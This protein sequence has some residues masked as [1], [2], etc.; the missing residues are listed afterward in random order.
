MLQKEL[1]NT[2]SEKKVILFISGYVFLLLFFCS[3]MSPLFYSNEWA[4]VNIY[5]NVAK[6]MLNGRTLYTETFDHKGPF[7]FFIYGLG[8]LI[9]DNSFLGMFLIQWAAWIAMVYFVYKL[10][11]LYLDNVFSYIVAFIFPVFVMKIMKVGGSAEEFILVF[12]CISLYYF[13]KYF[14]EKDALAHKPSTM[15][16]HGLLCSMVF[17]TKLNLLVFW[18]FPLAAIFLNLLLKKEFKNFAL[19][20]LAYLGGFLVVASPILFYLYYNDALQEA[21]SVYIELNRKYAELQSIS[22]T[23]E[24]ILLRVVYL[25]IDP[26]SLFLMAMVGIFHFPLKHIKHTL[27]K[28]SL[29]LSGV[30]LYI[31]MFMSPVF[32]VYY[33]IVFLVFSMLGILSLFIYISKFVDVK[34]NITPAYI[35]IITVVFV[36]MGYSQGDLSGNR[37]AQN[38]IDL[39]PGLITQKLHDEIMKEKDPTLLNIG[40]GLGN[41]LFTTCNIVPNVRY[42]VSPN[43]TYE[44]YPQLRDEQTK[45]IENKEIKF[46]VA[47]LSVLEDM[48]GSTKV[49]KR[50]NISNNKYF[51]N[52][53]AFKENYELILADTVSNTIDE[54]GSEIYQ[55]YKLK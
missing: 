54:G 35:F 13:V 26:F 27:G 49:Q 38:A 22:G 47:Q 4:D 15:F 36:Y 51:F 50:R 40:F 23:I 34:R 52:L 55:L 17:F 16:I 43:L 41:S 11:R 1:F 21:Y 19:N 14:K 39:K 30:F 29:L 5:F 8:C 10:S 12:E 42:F 3:H 31:I 46:I 44:S 18:F 48:D 2:L 20:I 24:L 28:Y 6:A 32:Q 45:Y 25:F 33:P 9:S 53:P 7:I 37:I